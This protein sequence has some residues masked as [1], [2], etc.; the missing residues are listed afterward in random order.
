MAESNPVITLSPADF[1]DTGQ[2]KLIIYVSRSGMSAYL[3][4]LSDAEKPIVSLFDVSWKETEGHELLSKIENVIYDHPGVLDDYAT[5][6][7][8]ESMQTTFAPTAI[9]EDVEDSEYD[10]Y[11]TLY[12][13][14]GED[15]TPD[16]CEDFTALFS[17]APGLEDF[18]MRTIPGARMR[19]HLAILAARFRRQTSDAPRIYLDLRNGE[20]DILAF[21]DSNLLSASSQPW[22]AIGDIAYRVFNLLN[23]Y[24]INPEE[25]KICVS[26]NVE[27]KSELM[28]LLRKHCGYVSSTN[29]P[30]GAAKG[31][32][33]TAA[34]L[35]AY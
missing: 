27:V 28:T 33:P 31:T 35:L 13:G 23:V 21:R 22:G 32:L 1:A 6:I 15:V 8:V 29:L 9:L 25:A 5:E 12:P 2:W 14:M 26:G 24:S 16:S 18:I 30:G 4:H 10:I 34:L 11:Q 19:S 3:K 20:V 17:L 7:V